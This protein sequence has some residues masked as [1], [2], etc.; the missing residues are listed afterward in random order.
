M[1]LYNTNKLFILT[2][3]SSS[4]KN[5]L[6]T[7]IGAELFS[8]S[9]DD[10]RKVFLQ[11]DINEYGNNTINNQENSF[12]YNKYLE[13]LEN[14]MLSGGTIISNNLN[15]LNKDIQNTIDLAEKYKYEAYIVPMPIL[16]TEETLKRNKQKPLNQ[17]VPEK[18]IYKSIALAKEKNHNLFI[19][20]V[21]IISPEEMKKIL[22]K[23]KNKLLFD[24][25][26]YKNI[27]HIGD[28]Q[29]C[30]SVL[31]DAINFNDKL[32][33]ENFYIFVGDYIDRGIENDKVMNL[34]YQLK[35]KKNVIF[36]RGNHEEHIDRYLSTGKY[37]SSEFYYKTL[38]QL[39]KKF[40]NE[41]NEKMNQITEKL[42]DFFIYKY[43][44]KN[45]FVNH[46][47]I[48]GLPEFPLLSSRKQ[49]TKGYGGYNLPIDSMFEEQNSDWVQIHGH[50]N[51][52]NRSSSKHRS[53]SLEM[54]VENGGYLPILTLNKNGFSI[55]HH[56]N[57]IYKKEDTNKHNSSPFEK[58]YSKN[59]ERD[60]PEL[61][62]KLTNSDLIRVVDLGDNIHS[63]NFTKKAFFDK[64]FSD[65]NTCKARGLFINVKN[66]KIVARSYDK[67]FN[68]E[69][70]GIDNCSIDYIKNEFKGK[71]IGYQK[72][73]GFLGISGYNSEKDEVLLRG[74]SGI[75]SPFS[76]HFFKIFMETL[77]EEQQF[78]FKKYLR[79]KNL[80]ATFEV[81]EPDFDPH[82][83]EYK[84]PEI[85]LLDL[86]KRE[87]DFKKEDFDIVNDFAQ[88]I[89][90]RTNKNKILNFKN[91]E[92][93]LEFRESLINKCPIEM[94]DKYKHEGYVIEDSEGK[95]IKLKSP[96]YD[97]WKSIRGIKDKIARQK[98]KSEK[99]KQQKV[100]KAEELVLNHFLIRTEK[101]KEVGVDFINKIFD[102][103]SP[104]EA[105]NKD[106]I[107]LRKEYLSKS[108]LTYKPK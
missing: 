67:F 63:F 88:K 1:K 3:H 12:I 21:N 28:L 87:I 53:F 99:N 54:D 58:L 37:V 81:I 94:P 107:T 35:D 39:H 23:N 89:N 96:Y 108:N 49:Y 61:V 104:E 46:A 66:N 48:S 62:N 82:I 103:Y 44:D 18:T 14:R 17:R 106:I 31:N 78:F 100:N 76:D 9:M 22:N 10:L 7:D 64:N 13:I 8:I 33:N 90:V 71:I 2:G 60:I 59:K 51:T 52:E 26:G 101:S 65:P 72:E 57:N 85:I 83:V 43:Q 47:G 40:K 6:I 24:L 16:T 55:N 102:T 5:T 84:K 27:Y 77:N 79:Q 34:L 91:V 56:P 4:G 74:K 42:S 68:I 95:L 36:I 38:P 15:L 70:K 75:E 97:F 20:K 86:V 25:N 30:Y 105:L 73:N 11:P 45:V 50:R 32:F 69:E 29:G 19:G 92:N 41:F 80:T 93:F 98:I